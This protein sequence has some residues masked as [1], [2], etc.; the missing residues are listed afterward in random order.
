MKRSKCLHISLILN[1]NKL[2]IITECSYVVNR[3]TISWLSESVIHSYNY[4]VTKDRIILL[5]RLTTW[6]HNKI[7]FFSRAQMWTQHL[8]SFPHSS[9]SFYSFCSFLL[10]YGIPIHLEFFF[11]QLSKTEGGKYYQEGSLLRLDVRRS[12]Y[13]IPFPESI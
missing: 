8:I 4:V 10:Y 1:D 9:N 12:R 3:K 13:Q 2:K 5:V 6:I 11:P 7:C